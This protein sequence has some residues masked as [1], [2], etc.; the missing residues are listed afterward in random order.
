MNFKLVKILVD[1]EDFRQTRHLKEYVKSKSNEALR[2]KV[3][4][5]NAKIRNDLR[6]EKDFVF[7]FNQPSAG[8]KINPGIKIKVI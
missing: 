4:E 3:G 6:L 8:Y 7:I 5:I 2:K 1:T